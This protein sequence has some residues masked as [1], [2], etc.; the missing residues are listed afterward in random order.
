L[1]SASTNVLPFIVNLINS[2]LISGTV[3]NCLKQAIVRPLLK[4]PGL[5]TNELSNYRPVSNLPFIGKLLEKVV[6]SQIHNYL[7]QYDLYTKFQSAYRQYHSTETAL[8]RVHNDILTSIDRKEEVILVLLDLSAALDT[9]DHS[10]LL[11]RLETRYGIK[12]LALNWFKSYL[13]GRSQSVCVDNILSEPSELICGVPQGS[14]LGPVLFTLYS[15][16]LEDIIKKHNLNLMI[17]ADDTQL[18]ITCE[19]AMDANC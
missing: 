19:S 16:P 10:I 4:K 3:P 11:N 13:E 12:G 8:L 15:A 2:S 9:I 1:K 18:Y 6:L 14:V 7:S 5:D 17:Y